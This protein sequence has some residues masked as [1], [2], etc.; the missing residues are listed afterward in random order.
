V[1]HRIAI[2]IEVYIHGMNGR[3]TS[4]EG[5]LTEERNNAAD[6]TA[7]GRT[8][9][10]LSTQRVQLFF[11]RPRS[12]FLFPSHF[13][14]HLHFWDLAGHVSPHLDCIRVDY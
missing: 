12:I 10:P 11:L 13:H 14:L 3:G 6:N 1:K 7:N 2:E 4:R 5:P 8:G 9:R